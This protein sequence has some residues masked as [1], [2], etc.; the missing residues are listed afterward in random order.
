M[1]SSQIT[2]L[3]LRVLIFGVVGLGG[4]GMELL[5]ALAAVAAYVVLAAWELGERWEPMDWTWHMRFA[6]FV[7]IFLNAADSVTKGS[8]TIDLAYLFP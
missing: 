6:K 2:S 1:T 8:L 7:V 4:L 3:G 5:D